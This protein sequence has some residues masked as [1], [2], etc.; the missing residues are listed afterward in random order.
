MEIDTNEMSF[1]GVAVYPRRVP[2]RSI[3]T[4]GMWTSVTLS[5]Q[6]KLAMIGVFRYRLKMNAFAVQENDAGT[7]IQAVLRLTSRAHARR[8]AAYIARLFTHVTG[9]RAVLRELPTIETVRR[10]LAVR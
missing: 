6:A 4:V 5:R 7:S 2:L 8:T 1:N 3:V 10:A 9:E